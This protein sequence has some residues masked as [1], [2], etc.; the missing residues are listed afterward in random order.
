MNHRQQAVEQEQK[1]R[2]ATRGAPGIQLV[3]D[4]HQPE[5]IEE[6][7]RDQSDDQYEDVERE[8]LGPA[9]SE[10]ADLAPRRRDGRAEQAQHHD[11]GRVVQA[12]G[13]VVVL[14]V[15]VG[16]EED[17]GDARAAEDEHAAEDAAVRPVEVDLR[18]RC[19]RGRHHARELRPPVEVAVHAVESDERDEAVLD[20]EREEV[21]RRAVQVVVASRVR[22]V[23]GDVSLFRSCTNR[24]VFL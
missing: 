1:R 24:V 2:A 7:R 21:R 16:E 15:E 9:E 17:D 22:R 10:Y 11:A 12:P 19:S 18:P 20:D 6:Q 8:V 13:Q 3:G 23:A 5:E 4:G 14:V